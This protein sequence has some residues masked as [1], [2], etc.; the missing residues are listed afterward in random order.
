V[1]ITPGAQGLLEV[2]RMGFGLVLTQAAVYEKL[3]KPYFSLAYRPQHDDFTGED[4]FFCRKAKEAGFTPYIDL[5][6]SQEIGHLGEFS[7][8]L[9][10]SDAL[11]AQAQAEG[12]QTLTAG[13]PHGP[14]D[15]K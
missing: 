8:S 1:Y 6:M 11:R 10:H 13:G 9:E 7:F 4:V 3:E 12:R 14:L 15:T 5:G 2:S